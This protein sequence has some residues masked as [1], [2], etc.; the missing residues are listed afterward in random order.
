MQYL[1]QGLVNLI[2]ALETSLKRICQEGISVRVKRHQNL[3]K[4]FR[5]GIRS[6]ELETIPKSNNIS[7]NTLTAAYYPKGV[8]GS[9]LLAKMSNNNVIIAGGLL[10]EIKTSYF[11]IGHMGSVSSSD[12]IIVL[13]A[14]ERALFELGHHIVPGKALQSF[15]N[16]VNFNL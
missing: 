15:R 5:A 4:A 12:L 10:P 14:L 6:L 2:V 11:R 1:S 9:A 7:A 16:T 8:D 13:G 3:A